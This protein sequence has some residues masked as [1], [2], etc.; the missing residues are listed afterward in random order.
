M[1]LFDFIRT[2]KSVYVLKRAQFILRDCFDISITESEILKSFAWDSRFNDYELA[3]SCLA[4]HL[5]LDNKEGWVE[6]NARLKAATA[7]YTKGFAKNPIALAILVGAISEM[8]KLGTVNAESTSLKLSIKIITSGLPSTLLGKITKMSKPPIDA[9]STS[10]STIKPRQLRFPFKKSVGLVLITENIDFIQ[11]FSSF[12]WEIDERVQEAVKTINIPSDKVVGISIGS[13]ETDLSFLLDCDP[14]PVVAINRN[15]T[16]VTNK[17]FEI[18]SS[19][20]SLEYLA[21][22][23]SNISIPGL[24]KLA[25]LTRLEFLDLSI[26]SITDKALASLLQFPKLNYLHLSETQ[27]TDAGLLHLSKIHTLE[28]INLRLT[29]ATEAAIDKLRRALPNCEITSS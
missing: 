27:I 14:T 4:L 7:L 1:G 22:V 19:F 26:S 18:L 9:P 16:K 21:F 25:S 17:D 8:Y 13:D 12:T 15:F 23:G 2:S 10:K 11:Y 20:S 29:K 28:F 24:K 6:A 3:V 5:P